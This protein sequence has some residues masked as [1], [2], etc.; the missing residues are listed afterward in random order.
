M[1]HL[2]PL[3]TPDSRMNSENL[4]VCKVKPAIHS[5]SKAE[6]SYKIL[7]ESSLAFPT[8]HSSWEMSAR[9]GSMYSS[10]VWDQSSINR[11]TIL[12]FNINT[13]LKRLPVEYWLLL[14]QSVD[15]P[16]SPRTLQLLVQ[17]P[18]GSWETGSVY[19]TLKLPTLP[20]QPVMYW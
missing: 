7:E 12:G 9:Q 10:V 1:S 14:I 15:Y 17:K 16:V 5:L 6:Q 3:R 2:S 11:G 4:V 20:P 18:E 19:V 13:S 8:L